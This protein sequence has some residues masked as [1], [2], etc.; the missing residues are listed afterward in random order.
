M[1]KDA[2]V[3]HG[4]RRKIDVY[5]SWFI[6]CGIA[7]LIT[8]L[9]F[10]SQLVNFSDALVVINVFFNVY[11]VSASITVLHWWKANNTPPSP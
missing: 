1:M 4:G 8:S 7:V 3:N 6:M 5:N 2:D 11:L 10:G 9:L